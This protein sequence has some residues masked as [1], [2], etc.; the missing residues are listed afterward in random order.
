MSINVVCPGCYKRF[1]VSEQFAGKRGPCPNCKT[2]ID[3][4]KEEVKIHT[5]D[6]FVSGGKTIKGRTILQPLTRLSTD[7]K[8]KDMVF[9]VVGLLLV[10]GL[11]MLFPSFGLGLGLLNIIG[12]I[13]L[14]L[15]V[16]PLVYF[17]QR[18]LKDGDDLVQSDSVDILRKCAIC[19]GAYAF[20]WVCFEFLSKYMGADGLFIW[21]YLVP[22]ALF[23]MFVAHVV[24]DLDFAR[25]LF[26][27]LIFF[28]PVILLR[29][30]MGLGWIWNA[31][32]EITSG[33][34]TP[35]PPPP[36]TGFGP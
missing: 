27:Y 31:A 5:P 13:G 24:F 15:I 17:G 14:F 32:F 9:S 29:G 4:P 11:A 19:G 36:P 12:F 7:L 28:V 34:G 22:F 16:F 25:G 20:L 3:I 6:E 18:L 23:S 33:S 8:A 26:H 1:Q 2:L 10:L 21:V 30:L 35:P